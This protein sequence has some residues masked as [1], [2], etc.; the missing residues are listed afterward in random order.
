MR[1]SD[2]DRFQTGGIPCAPWR[3]ARS[4]QCLCDEM[5]YRLVV[6]WIVVASSVPAMVSRASEEDPERPVQIVEETQAG[7]GKGTSQAQAAEL[8]ALILRLDA[9]QFGERLVRWRQ[10]AGVDRRRNA[11]S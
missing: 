5:M 3:Y 11:R 8:P 1:Q 4:R 2:Q 9:E 7:N 6:A 10:V